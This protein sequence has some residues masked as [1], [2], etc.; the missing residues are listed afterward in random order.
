MK[1]QSIAF[2]NLSLRV[3]QWP[4]TWKARAL[5]LCERETYFERGCTDQFEAKRAAVDFA[6]ARLFGPRLKAIAETLSWRPADAAGLR[7]EFS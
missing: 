3:E 5:G 1:E 7:V 2:A 4:E 6:L